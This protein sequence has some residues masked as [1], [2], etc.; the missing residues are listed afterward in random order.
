MQLHVHRLLHNVLTR[1]VKWRVIDRNPC[2]MVDAPRAERPEM[3]IWDIEQIGTFMRV[4]EGSPY[5]DLF[6][7]EIDTA[8]RRNEALAIRW[9]A[10]NLEQ[11]ALEV[12]KGL[13]RLKGRGLV[14]LDTKTERSRRRI[15]LSTHAVELLRQVKG[16]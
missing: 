10:V 4:A 1:A 6:A 16:A 3:A 12:R 9:L 15:A 11:G 13:H 14:E 8:M 2:Q 7:L 5:R